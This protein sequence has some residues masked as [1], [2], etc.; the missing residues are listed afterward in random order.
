MLSFNRFTRMSLAVLP[1]T[2]RKDKLEVLGGRHV[3][4]TKA[5]D[6]TGPGTSE[7][8]DCAGSGEL[9]SVFSCSMLPLE[10]YM[11]MVHSLGAIGVVDVSPAQGPNKIET[12]H[13]WL[14]NRRIVIT[15]M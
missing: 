9:E 13:H 5:A 4:L 10:Y 3:F 1:V 8:D 2:V 14:F 7:P 15:A 6:A 11:E 12:F